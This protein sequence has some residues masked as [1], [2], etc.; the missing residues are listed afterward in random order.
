MTTK[1]YR[2]LDIELKIDEKKLPTLIINS[3]GEVLT[4][5]WSNGQLIPYVYVK[6]PKDGIYEFDFVADAPDGIVTQVITEIDANPFRWEDY[7]PE[8]KGVK[9]YASINSVVKKI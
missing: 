9:V 1:I 5:G 6:P 3:R 2:V 7:P 8:L 4:G